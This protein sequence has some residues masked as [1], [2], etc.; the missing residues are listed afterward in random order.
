MNR[1]I[2]KTMAEN[3]ASIMKEKAYGKKIENAA[4][5]INDM[6]ENLVR[7]YV[8]SPVIA[9]ANEYPTYMHCVDGATITTYIDSDG[10]IRS[11]SQIRGELSFKI[12]Y[13][14]NYITVTN[15]EYA[16]LRKLDDER[17]RLVKVRDDFEKKVYDALVAL[18]TENAVKKELPEA[19]DYLEFPEEKA[20]PMEIYNDLRFIIGK[21]NEK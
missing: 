16:E 9:C 13:R 2:T 12:P 17:R 5:K 7:K 18:R 3:A 10:G 14:S 6:V 20:V 4:S 8:P 1:R 19:L 21:I 11:A 15:V